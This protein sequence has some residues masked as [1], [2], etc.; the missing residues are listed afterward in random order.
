M[1]FAVVEFLEDKSV[2]VV[3]SSWMIENAICLWPPYRAF[4]L[5]A[6]VKKRENHSQRGPEIQPMQWHS[7]VS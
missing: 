2:E 4:R 7:M 3:P 1:S 6:A 5:T